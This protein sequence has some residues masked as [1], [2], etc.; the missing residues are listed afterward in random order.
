MARKKESEKTQNLVPLYKNPDLVD[1]DMIGMSAHFWERF[2]APGSETRKWSFLQHSLF[3]IALGRIKDW[4]TG[5]NNNVVTFKNFKI[6]QELGWDF[7]EENFRKIG[8]ILR[9]EFDY[10]VDHSKISLQDVTTGNWYTGNLIVEAYGDSNITHVVL[11]H[12]FMTHFENLYYL[13]K[14][15]SQSFHQLLE[16]D[17]VGF[18]SQYSKMLYANLRSQCVVKGKS[19]EKIVVYG[20]NELKEILGIDKDDYMR[21][22]DFDKDRYSGFDFTAFEKRVLNPAIAEINKSELIAILPWDDGKFYAKR[23]HMRRVD[24]YALKFK[25]YDAETIKKQRKSLYQ[26]ALSDGK[27]PQFMSDFKEEVIVEAGWEENW[28]ATKDVKKGKEK[29]V[30][31]SSKKDFSKISRNDKIGER[32]R[33]MLK[34]PEELKEY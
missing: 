26:A 11:N 22:K 31:T 8:Q 20:I 17:M 6:M 2:F 3:I 21:V 12:N 32:A 28:R 16:S 5:G 30:T 7:T 27:D 14:N 4:R 18:K 13:A 19:V 15:Y 25:V 33:D 24:G 23:K 1:K 29:K 10:M 9:K 34:V